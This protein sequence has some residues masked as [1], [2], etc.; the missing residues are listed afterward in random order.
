MP[1]MSPP[2]DG[3][4][5]PGLARSP[6]LVG[7]PAFAR[8]S[9]GGSGYEVGLAVGETVTLLHPPSTFSR[10]FNRDGERASAK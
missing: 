6:P 1:S 3:G 8:R 9:G 4:A 5:S 2:R 7:A 10:C